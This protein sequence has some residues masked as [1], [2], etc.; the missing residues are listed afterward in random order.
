[1]ERTMASKPHG[2][3][4]QN[5]LTRNRPGE[6]KRRETGCISCGKRTTA[7]DAVCRACRK[8]GNGEVAARGLEGGR[9]MN[10]GGVQRWVENPKPQPS[11]TTQARQEMWPKAPKGRV[12]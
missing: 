3:K 6:G 2:P 11:L 9:W 4:A 8:D 1:M 5:E 12:A 10:V 7:K